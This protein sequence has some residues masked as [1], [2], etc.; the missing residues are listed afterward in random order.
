MQV[1]RPE[2]YEP[3]RRQWTYSDVT[4]SLVVDQFQDINK[5][6]NVSSYRCLTGLR[7]IFDELYARRFSPVMM[8]LIE[9]YRVFLNKV[10][11]RMTLG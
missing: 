2:F 11:P 3:G 8:I 6:L 1:I 9:F 7:D 5:Y 10:L 4:C